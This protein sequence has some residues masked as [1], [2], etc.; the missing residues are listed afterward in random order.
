MD[1]QQWL[2]IKLYIDAHVHKR[3]KKVEIRTSF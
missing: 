2:N 3:Q 1:Q